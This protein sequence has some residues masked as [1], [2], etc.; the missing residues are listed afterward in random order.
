MPRLFDT[1]CHLQF[2]KFDEDHDAVI[3]RC[4]E[5]GMK[6]VMPSSQLDTSQKA[7]AF[8]TKY[9]DIYAGVGLH[10]IHVVDEELDEA[11]YLRLA[12]DEHTVG[13]GEIGL[14]K[15][16][17]WAETPEEEEQIFIKQKK[18]F[19]QQLAI[20]EQA[21]KTVI[22]HCRD[23]YDQ[24]LDV[25]EERG[26]QGR[27][28]IHCFM[29]NRAQAKRFMAFGSYMGF[30]GVI[31]FKNAT[32]E[33]LEVVKEVP[34]DRILLETDAPYL[35]PVPHRGKRNEPLYVE[36]VARKIAEL[37]GLRYEEVVE[38]TW[39]NAHTVFGIKE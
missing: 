5:A 12:Q 23:A 15:Y 21:K 4:F 1:H 30:T 31:T 35:T 8:A 17:I 14:D 10:P 22:M 24:L 27:H 3:A 29:G 2:E 33:L 25:I 36:F 26:I 34:L 16:R 6:M 19:L 28:L 7:V 38:A 18:V 20:A 39:E 13:V 9:P 37:K 11:E 32:P